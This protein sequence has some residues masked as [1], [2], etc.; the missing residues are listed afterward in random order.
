M[1]GVKG[2]ER[3]ELNRSA[4]S[5]LLLK[6]EG[7]K[8]LIS[9]LASSVSREAGIGTEISVVDGRYRANARISPATWEDY[10]TNLSTNCLLKALHG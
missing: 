7:T 10:R 3:I 8:A 5:S 9:S 1:A 6:G 2:I 4:V